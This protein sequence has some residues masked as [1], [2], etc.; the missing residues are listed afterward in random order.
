MSD[1]HSPAEIRRILTQ[2]RTIAV[3]G[4]SP[5]PERPSYGV[6]AFLQARGH[7]IVPVNPGHAGQ[8]ILGQTVYA[9][10]ADIPPEIT[11]DMVDV[12]RASEAVPGIVDEALAALPG[13]RAIWLQLGVV[14]PQAMAKAHAAGLDTVWDR[15]PKI[16]Y[17]RVIDL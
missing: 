13:L 2:A 14:H 17:A 15:C 9:R 7:R 16:E 3:V 1:H 6:A 4:L 12:F 10:L 11:V 5:R 8:T